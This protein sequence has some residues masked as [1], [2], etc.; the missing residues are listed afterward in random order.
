M[1]VNTSCGDTKNNNETLDRHDRLKRRIDSTENCN[2]PSKS[3]ISSIYAVPSDV[4]Y[5]VDMNIV[6]FSPFD[7]SESKEASITISNKRSACPLPLSLAS[8]KMY[9][10]LPRHLV[11]FDQTK[12]NIY[13]GHSETITVSLPQCT[14]EIGIYLDNPSDS[15]DGAP[16][17][18]SGQSYKGSLIGWTYQMNKR[19]IPEENDILH[20]WGEFDRFKGSEWKESFSGLH[21]L[22]V[23]NDDGDGHRNA[24]P[25]DEFCKK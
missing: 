14:A 25:E 9:G 16:K 5:L 13:P 7:V 4:R 10:R 8:Y 20:A 2:D 24:L 17:N 18:Q 11:R 22:Y 23:N 12:V 19:D 1:L 3:V 6:N 15:T 21:S